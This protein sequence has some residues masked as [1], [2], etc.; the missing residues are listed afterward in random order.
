[1]QPQNPPVEGPEIQYAI[2]GDVHIAYGTVGNGPIDV[3][4]VSGWV[5]SNFGVPWEGS[6]L[7]FYRGMSSFAR[8]ILFDK[9]GLGMSDR[10]QGIP[11]LETRMDDIRAVMDAVGSERAA[12]MGFSEGGPMSVLFAAT[13]PE[14][15]AALVLYSTP[16]SWFR[17]D[18]YPWAE[19][20]DEIRT[21]LASE[22]GIRGTDEWYNG[23]LRELAPS[24]ARD[25]ATQRWWRRWVQSSASPGAIKAMSLMNS[26]INVCHALPAIQVPTLALNRTGDEDVPIESMRYA[27]DRIPG[28]SFVELDGIDHGWWVNSAQIVA[29]IEPFLTGLRKR[30]EWDLVKTNRVLATVLFTDIADSTAKLAE[31]GDAAWREL[32]EAHHAL[33]RRQLVRYS[34]REID[35][36]GDGFFAS[37]DGPARAIRCAQ[38]I[39]DGVR[40]LGLHVRAGLH[41]GECEV[42]GG[43]IGGIAVHIGARVAAEAQPDE[44]V[45]SSTV[46]DL[47]AGSGLT[48]ADRGQVELKGVPGEWHLYAVD[49]ALG[50]YRSGRAVATTAS[51]PSARGFPG[52]PARSRV[53]RGGGLRDEIELERPP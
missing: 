50:D 7:D 14:R 6:A 37:F 27:A 49:P 38:A 21:W 22:E 9:R 11:D 33:I 31:V 2:S 8:L 52:P 53:S 30:D 24:T 43:K 34:G 28:A 45:V 25:P 48:F 17:T 44:V 39:S 16:L 15:T 32:V 42:V 36:A 47:V 26:E 51:F 19:T 18:E 35:T 3:V 29:E 4:F 12:I 40:E 20:R 13:Y 23:R 10:A 5:L 46:K 41:T 1:V